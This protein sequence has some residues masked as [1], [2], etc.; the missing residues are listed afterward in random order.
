M[1]RKV[2]GPLV[3]RVTGWHR[4]APGAA[5]ATTFGLWTPFVLAR[6]GSVVRVT[7]AALVLGLVVAAT[8]ASAVGPSTILVDDNGEQCD[9]AT[10]SIQDAIDLANPGDTIEVCAGTY[11]EQ[12]TVGKQ[13]DIVGSTGAVVQPTTAPAAGVPDVAIDAANVAIRQLTFDFNGPDNG[14]GGL[15]IFV[16]NEGGPATT[17]VTISD[18]EMT[19]GDGS[20]EVVGCGTA[21]Q[22]GKNADVSDLSITGNQIH[23]DAD[24]MGEGIYVNP[25][26]GTGIVID[27]NTIDGNL[28]AGISVEASKVTVSENDIQDTSEGGG[29]N[30][31]IRVIDLSGNSHDGVSLVRNRVQDMDRG[32]YVGTDN[33]TTLRVSASNNEL[34]NNEYGIYAYAGA[35]LTA[36]DNAITDNATHN[37][38]LTGSGQTVDASRNWWGSDNPTAVNDTIQVDNGS[39]DFTPLIGLGTDTSDAFGF[40]PSDQLHVAHPYG[41]QLNGALGATSLVLR[42]VMIGRVQEAIDDTGENGTVKVAAS[43]T[44][45]NEDLTITTDGLTLT[46]YNGNPGLAGIKGVATQ[47]Q[48]SFPDTG[49]STNID[50]RANN[51]TVSDLS[52]LSPDAAADQRSSGLV[53]SGT[54]ITITGNRFYTNQAGESPDED[55]N[56][57]VAIQTYSAD[58]MPTSDIDGLRIQRQHLQW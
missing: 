13:L 52:L 16:S 6:S 4:D 40:Q 25:G 2:R 32:L 33:G 54:G 44:A 3:E 10:T 29:A 7:L 36:H 11:D 18:N 22:T 58:A 55:G 49:S 9:T 15:G 43:E 1:A 24:G 30:A 38:Y 47:T 23:G 50:V 41:S 28:Y 53:L 51:V 39:A 31:G 26:P 19:T 35:S 17:G 20:C 37:L 42:R 8:P 57:S 12:L 21:I 48:S 34:L 27:G 5:G 56:T 14:R 46:S 45:Y